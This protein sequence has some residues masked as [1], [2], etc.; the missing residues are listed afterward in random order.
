MTKPA[1]N[2]L[3][4]VLVAVLVG[5]LVFVAC[6]VGGLP[7]SQPAV[8]AVF[9]LAVT[10]WVTEALPLTV[11]AFLAAAMLVVVGGI[12]QKSVF[13]QFG[14]SVILLFIGSFVLAKAFEVNGVHE[15]IA[16]WI[17]SKK[18]VVKSPANLILAVGAVCLTFSLFISNTATTAMMLPIVLSL[19][20]AVGHD[21]ADSKLAPAMLL[22][23]TW[24]ASFAVGTPVST[25]PNAIGLG[26]IAQETGINI[27]FGQWMLFAMPISITMLLI[28]WS[29]LKLI[30][31]RNADIELPDNIDIQKSPGPLSSAG[32]TVIGIFFAV[33][34][35]WLLPDIAA[36]IKGKDHAFVQALD[37]RLTSAAAALIGLALCFII[38]VKGTE[39]GR[40]LTWIQAKN[41]D[42]GT[43]M[44]IG[45]GL[46]L[47][48]AMFESGLAATM[49]KGVSA[50]STSLDG[51]LMGS[52]NLPS[53]TVFLTTLFSVILV[54]VASE[55]ASNTAS[56][57]AILPIVI[58]I[59]QGAGISPI[60]PALA[61]TIA[62]SLGFMLPVSTP[63]NAIAYSS[64]YLSAKQMIK[65]GVWID[66]IG[67]IV[68]MALTSLILPL[69]GLN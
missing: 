14:S 13:S 41:I 33:L 57:S 42:W 36:M 27:S 54:V 25:P 51:W 24:G 45:G 44:L 52:F 65:A 30:H 47:G 34:L 58:G 26:M 23:L 18:W 50:V 61:V 32:K 15:R 3:W 43:V 19:L 40:V 46:A 59:A 28:G 38:P 8:A 66:I 69:L 5:V 68:V 9:G 53:S 62:A 12:S 11:T 55:L 35:M 20:K 4:K 60:G 31:L 64:G 10:L 48:A 29:V 17:L 37:Q 49:G 67:I 63:P 21:K 6:D 2:S 56:V 7:D 22:M 39:S 1:D 16:R